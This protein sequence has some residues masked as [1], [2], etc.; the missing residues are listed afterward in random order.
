MTLAATS[1]AWMDQW[2][3]E[4]AGLLWNPPGAFAEAAPTA[5]RI[6][7]IRETSWYALGLVLRD[8]PSDAERAEVAL[9]AI[10]AQQ[11]NEPGT[12]WHG[13]FARFPESPRPRPGAV[14]WV[15]YDPNWRQFIG[16]ALA[17]IRRHRPST[18]PLVDAAIELAVDGEPPDRV[19]AWYSNIALMRAWLDAETGRAAQGEELAASVVELFDRHGAFHEYN[20]PTYYGIDLFALGLWRSYPPTPAFAAWGDHLEAAL[21]RDIGRYWHAGIGTGNLA[22]PYSRAY[23]M[24]MGAY[25]ANLGLWLWDTLGP[26]RA[27]FPDTATDFD[28]SH[29]FCKG[30]AVELLGARIPDD[31]APHFDAFQGERLVEQVITEQPSRVATA[32]LGERAMV[33]GEAGDSGLHA[34]GQFHPATVHWDAGDG[35]VGWVRAE[36][37]GP[38]SATARPGELL[39]RCGPHPR[40]GPQPVTFH[41]SCP[42]E[43]RPLVSPTAWS[44]PG[45]TIAVRTEAS[46]VA[47]EHGAVTIVRYG[48]TSEMVL[49]LA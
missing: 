47:L 34:R 16:T 37:H 36:H 35:R 22:G 23:G 25:A 19:G 6:H 40:R 20:S 39:I 46:P 31:T 4:D 33:G 17:L 43:E 15:D 49:C 30:P 8:G 26:E 27:P 12:V 5:R 48:P 41:I 1:M 18:S 32:W 45:Q 13:T 44:L 24:D 14:E 10:A 9:R 2:F 3:D 29:D 42:G 28:H 38:T 21:W 7:M 11:Y